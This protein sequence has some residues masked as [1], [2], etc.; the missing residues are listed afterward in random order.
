MSR[1]LGVTASKLAE[2]RASFLAGG[3]VALKS[4]QT[5][6]RD[7]ELRSLREKVGDLTMRLELHEKFLEM[8][9]V[10]GPLA[11]RRSRR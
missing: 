8:R 7:E 1:E 5:D 6:V 3:Q 11:P 4:R 9:G 2:W 10:E